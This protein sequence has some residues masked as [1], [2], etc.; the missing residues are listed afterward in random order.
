MKD[1]VEWYLVVIAYA[2]LICALI[3]CA[4]ENIAN[5]WKTVYISLAIISSF[6]VIQ[7]FTEIEK[8]KKTLIYIL[9]T[10]NIILTAY[11]SFVAIGTSFRIFYYAIMY[12]IIFCIKKDKAVFLC[13][14]LYILDIA[15]NYFKAGQT[16]MAVFLKYELYNLPEYVLV[17]VVLF[18]VKYIIE[19][20]K[21]LNT[22]KTELGTTNIQ[23]KDAFE[24]LS[25][26][27]SKNEDYLIMQEKNKLAREIHDTVGHTLT[28]AL[29]EME[30]SQVLSESDKD[31]ASEKLGYAIDQV[32]KGLNEVRH[33]VSA[34][35]SCSIDYCN[36]MIKIIEDTKKHTEI[37]IRY[38]IDDIKSENDAIKK[39]IFRALQEGIT[40][41]IRHGHASA[42]VFK[43]KY[44]EDY[45]YFSL[46]DNG[47]GASF[48]KKG[49]GISAMEDRVK[50]ANGDIQI[51]TEPGQG[52]NIYIKFIKI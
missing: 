11:L 36:E 3:F 32:R 35:N 37:I 12:E 31:K 21:S 27:Y 43:L 6:T 16:D 1:K 25:K 26:A 48:Y 24:T 41:S 14:G 49:F 46:E 8:S 19:M 29:V 2:V 39:C 47:R 10:V 17:G 7:L 52:F 50:E 22:A 28:T 4:L 40:N 23:L 30:A 51:M 44:T 38:D 20:N 18:L 34:L 33:S 42:L 9:I 13:S 15:A 45:L 5:P